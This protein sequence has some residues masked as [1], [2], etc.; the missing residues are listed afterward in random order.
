VSDIHS[1]GADKPRIRVRAGSSSGVPAQLVSWSG[2]DSFV[3]FAAKIGIGTQNQN[4]ASTYAFNFI[5]RNRM[6]LEA[7][8]RGSW[9]VGR[10]ID[11]PADDMTTAGIELSGIDGDDLQAMNAAIRDMGLGQQIADSI[12]WARLFGGAIAV[13]MIDGA[14]M[15]TPLNI[16]A[17]GPGAFK[18]LQVFD[19]TVITPTLGPTDLVQEMG[20]DFGLPAFYQTFTNGLGIPALKIHHTRALRQVGIKLPYYQSWVEGLWGEAVMERIWDRIVGFDSVTQGVIQLVYKAHLRLMKI[21]GLRNL[22]ATGGPMMEAVAKQF[23]FMRQ[24]QT[25]EGLTLSDADDEFQVFQYAFAGLDDVLV[26]LG[27][28]LCGALEIPRTRMFGTSPGGLD[29]SGESDLTTYDDG[30]HKDQ[31]AKLRRPWT[32]ILDVL[33]RSVL[34]R[35]PDPGFGFEFNPLHKPTAKEKADEGNTVTTA[36]TGAVNANIVSRQTALRELKQS[37]ESTGMWSTITDEEIEA[38]EDVAPSAEDLMLLAQKSKTPAEGEDPATTEPGEESGGRPGG[39]ARPALR[40][41]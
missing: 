31:E 22:I 15:S 34:G 36:V 28:Q 1:A 21:K 39:A 5:T 4:S 16:D 24:T 29:S 6:M 8:Y 19:R 3:N 12:R 41:A 23:D 7:A 10:A 32:V 40:A 14:D 38:A 20:P 9:I 25:A 35:K 11:I 33:H 26:A 27:D 18:G 2:G 30:V 17:I 13:L 37:S